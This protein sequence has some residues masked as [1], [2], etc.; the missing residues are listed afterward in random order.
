MIFFWKKKV[1]NTR[2]TTQS[3]SAPPPATHSSAVD[4]QNAT[5]PISQA[6]ASEIP[7]LFEILELSN[8]KV[9]IE[10]VIKLILERE[11][12]HVLL[13]KLEQQEFPEIAARCQTEIQAY[14][15]DNLVNFSENVGDHMGKMLRAELRL[16]M[17]HMISMEKN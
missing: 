15:R 2:S 3:T 17:M 1:I 7:V 6:K 5:K 12:H 9:A 8:S 11:R 13:T 4:A 10:A 14:L 16:A